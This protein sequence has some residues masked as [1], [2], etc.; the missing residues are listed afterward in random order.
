MKYILLSLLIFLLLLGA[1]TLSDV[2][3][4]ED[5]CDVIPGN[6]AIE[7]TV[8]EENRVDYNC[9]EKESCEWRSL[10]GKQNTYYT[11]CPRNVEYSELPKR[12]ILRID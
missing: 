4:I 6:K 9:E 11:C 3:N 5:M 2:A 8:L 7:K 1:C 12:C 10:G